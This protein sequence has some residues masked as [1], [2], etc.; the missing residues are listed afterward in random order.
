MVKA[1]AA[2][3][4]D[5]MRVESLV[6]S[7]SLLVERTRNLVTLSE[8]NLR[9]MMHDP[10]AKSYEIGDDV[11]G[12]PPALD[13]TNPAVLYPRAAQGRLEVKALDE[14]MHSMR[15]ARKVVRAGYLPRLD[16]FGNLYDQNP[17]QRFFGTG[18]AWHATWDV[19]AQLSWT[20]NDS[21]SARPQLAELEAKLLGIEASREQ[22]LDGI[23]LEVTQAC[24]AAR[25]ADLAIVTTQRQVAAAEESYRVRRVLYRAGKATTAELID[26]ETDWM[27]SRL[28]ALN[29]RIDARVAR[30]NLDHA[31]GRDTP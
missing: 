15:E 20:L 19:G 25:E 7:T 6:A 31:V 11:M 27:K 13:S 8:T 10:A 4:A 17:N 9:V 30:V 5:S 18:P 23:R 2:S 22:L 14:A 1:G 21:L 16:L 12:T 26:A 24:N 29:A 28:E 3:H